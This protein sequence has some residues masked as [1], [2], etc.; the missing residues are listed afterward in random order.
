MA[1]HFRSRTVR[2]LLG[3]PYWKLFNLIQ[4]NK[5]P[6]PKR[7]DVGDFLWS[8]ADIRRARQ[9]LTVDLRKPHN[10]KAVPA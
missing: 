6:E 10:K 8:E 7:D 4:S 3:V 2:K 9:A 1:K 5:I